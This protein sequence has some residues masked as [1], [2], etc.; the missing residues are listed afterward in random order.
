MN[1]MERRC[2][3][4]I[5]CFQNTTVDK[6]TPPLHH[7]I[8]I[9]Q[10]IHN[11]DLLRHLELIAPDSLDIFFLE[12]KAIRGAVAHTSAMINQMRA[13]HSL[14]VLES[15]VLGQA[16]TAA[17]LLSSSVKG[18]DRIALSV[19]CGGPIKGLVA[20]TDADAN[21]RGYLAQ[22]PIPVEEPM[23][24]FDI[25]PLFGPGFLKV[26][27]TLEGAKS[28][29]SGQI[30]L[31]SGNLAEDLAWYF[32]ESEQTKSFFSLS[33]HFDREGTITGAGGLF[34]QEMPGAEEE[35]LASVQQ[36]ALGMSSLGTSFAAGLTGPAIVEEHLHHHKPEFI[37]QRDIQ[38]FCSCS[39][40]RFGSFLAGMQGKQQEEILTQSEFPLRV[41]CHNCGSVYDFSRVECEELFSN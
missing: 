22:V 28:P 21:V 15:Y 24:S 18:Q 38:F 26:T 36:T 23:E 19:E 25:S 33:I 2:R 14:G 37:G 6:S 3:Y 13:N 32:L 1:D 8:M 4:R 20:E 39:R 5:T 31:R 34:L 35:T 11:P 27:K 40:E 10:P 16:Y 41:E 12:E 7:R 9:V 29:F 30:M 17:G